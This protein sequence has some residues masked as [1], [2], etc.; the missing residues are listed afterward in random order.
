MRKGR[1]G[2]SFV[3]ALCTRAKNLPSHANIFITECK[4]MELLAVKLANKLVGCAVLDF[5]AA[6][7]LQ[8]L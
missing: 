1:K 8:K 2:G 4:V 3:C 6:W 7:A 5:S